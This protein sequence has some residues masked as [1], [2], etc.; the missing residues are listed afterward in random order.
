M[1]AR[2]PWI[3]PNSIKFL[4]AVRELRRWMKQLPLESEQRLD[5]GTRIKALQKVVQQSVRNDK[6]CW[7]QS[8]RDGNECWP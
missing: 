5:V 1:K 8:R 7:L 4:A 2:K 3:S 6:T